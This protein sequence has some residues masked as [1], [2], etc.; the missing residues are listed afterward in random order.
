[1]TGT[2]T[3]GGTLNVTLT[4]G[5]VPSLTDFILVLLAGARNGTF[6]T[7]TGLAVSPTRVLFPFYFDLGLVLLPYD[8]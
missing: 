1:M 2:A 7:I 4:G 5:C 6:R 3:L 8:P